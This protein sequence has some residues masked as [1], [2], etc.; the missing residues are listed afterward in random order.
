M[1]KLF[2]IIGVVAILSISLLVATA[3]AVSGHEVDVCEPGG[4]T[5]GF[6]KNHTEAWYG[7]SPD[8][9]LE[10]SGFDIPDALRLDDY[11]CLEA[12]KFKGG[13]GEIGA[14]RILLRAAVAAYL[15]SECED[16]DINYYVGAG[17]V[18]DLTNSALAS[19]DRQTMLCLKDEFDYNN[20]LGVH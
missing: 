1:K 9:R 11:T 5:P 12:L 13:P 2:R 16:L 8:T 17:T 6:W 19:M 14:A 15:N 3:G 18:L 10:S 7:L 20:N 4:L